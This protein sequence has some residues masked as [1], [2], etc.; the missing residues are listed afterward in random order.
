VKRISETI[1]EQSRLHTTEE[2]LRGKI[3]KN[4]LT[5]KKKSLRVIS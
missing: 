1:R 3:L 4:E 5:E 2:L